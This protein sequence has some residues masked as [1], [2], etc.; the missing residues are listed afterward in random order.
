MR[1]PIPV[2]PAP[3]GASELLPS[4][5]AILDHEIAVTRR[6]VHSNDFSYW[7]KRDRLVCQLNAL[8]V[9]LLYAGHVGRGIQSL[10]Q[11][12]AELLAATLYPLDQMPASYG[13]RV[14]N[15][16]TIL[17]LN[18]T[19]AQMVA[20][21]DTLSRYWLDLARQAFHGDSANQDPLTRAISDSLDET[22]A[23]AEMLW[24]SR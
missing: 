7:N 2:I 16:L 24:P 20:D 1:T 21:S 5:P 9:A 17:N 19:I 11:A 13:V 14:D 18:L 4:D 12:R 15:L 22:A 23:A 6:M 8:G 10:E 3:L